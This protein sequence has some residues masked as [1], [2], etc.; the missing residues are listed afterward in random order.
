MK[1]ILLFLLG[2]LGFAFTGYKLVTMAQIRG[3]L[4]GARTATVTV[5]QMYE[6]TT[7]EK[8]GRNTYPV[9]AYW[10][11]WTNT[12]VHQP[13]NHRV[14]VALEEWGQLRVGAALEVIYAGFD[15]RPNTRKGVYASDGNFVFDLVL[16]TCEGLLMLG[17]AWV[18]IRGGPPVPSPRR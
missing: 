16:L 4:P 5:T 7:Q 11:S 1:G 12:D 9:T 8:A 13:G 3:W 14:D 15:Q 6:E 18:F 2:V 10:V 17:G